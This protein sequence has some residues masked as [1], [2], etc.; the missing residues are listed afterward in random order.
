MFDGNR[1]RVEN[2]S[3][4]E[5][6]ETMLTVR[7]LYRDDAKGSALM[8]RS[9]GLKLMRTPLSSKCLYPDGTLIVT[10]YDNPLTPCM[11]SSDVALKPISIL[12]EIWLSDAE[13]S[14]KNVL[15]NVLD[16]IK[17]DYFLCMNPTYQFEHKFYGRIEFCEEK[18]SAKIE[19]Y[20]G[21]RFVLKNDCEFILILMKNGIELRLSGA[22]LQFSDAK[23]CD[24]CRYVENFI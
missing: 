17:S 3:I 13:N 1:Y 15:D 8:E 9:D 12:D 24:C 14:S 21:T 20:N 4:V 5:E 23:C 11:P 2:D 22:E 6:L 7:E 10:S 16:S 19:L 18:F